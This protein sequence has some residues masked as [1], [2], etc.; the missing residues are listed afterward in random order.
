MRKTIKNRRW[1]KEDNGWEAEV[2][3]R[4]KCGWRRNCRVDTRRTRKAS[5]LEGRGRQTE[6]GIEIETDRERQ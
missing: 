4:W 6:T 1:G 2:R 5:L 3:W